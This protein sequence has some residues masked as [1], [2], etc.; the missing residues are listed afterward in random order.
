VAAITG[1]L[2]INMNGNRNCPYCK[3][4]AATGCEHLALAAAPRD[5]VRLCVEKSH[6][7]YVW[8]FICARNERAD[9]TWLETTFCERFLKPL[10]YFGVME[11][12]WRE[13]TKP[14][15]K[16]LWVLMWSRSPQQLWWE[17]RDAIGIQAE[18]VR[19]EPPPKAAVSCPVCGKDP[20]SEC[21]HLVLQGADLPTAE[22]VDLY[23]PRGAY[24]KLK[25]ARPDL[26]DRAAVFLREYRKMFP[27]VAA[28]QCRTWDEETLGLDGDYVYVWVR[29]PA[30]FENEL[31]AFLTAR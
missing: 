26:P 7:E 20:D 1:R 3:S 12:E 16:D 31:Q 15:Q 22:V 24:E 2:K 30:A 13:G 9:F 4:P 29:D 23:N 17:L 27:S 14:G 5:F 21:P 18:A 10:G 8:R 6:A 25:A 28:V 19:D 11:Y